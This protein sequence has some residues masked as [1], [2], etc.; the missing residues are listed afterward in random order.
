MNAPLF[1]VLTPVYNP[2]TGILQETIRSVLKQSFQDWELI[3]VDDAS[4]SEDIR[5]VLRH[6]ARRDRRIKLIERATNGGI[7]RASNDALAAAHGEFIALLDH[8][9]LLP[10][11]A[12][13]RVAE[14]LSDD[15]DYVYSD[16][17][18]FDE[19]GRFYDTFRKPDWSPERL[20]HHMYTGHL[21]VIR[22]GLVQAVGGFR[23]GFDGSQ[24]YDLVL[25]VSEKAR[26]IVHI[27]EV[28][29]HWR[30]IQGSA[31]LSLEAKTYA[32]PAGLRA[33][34]EHLER[35]GLDYAAAFGPAP[36]YYRILRSLDSN[37]KVSIIIPTRGSKG[38]VWGEPRFYVLEA[39]RTA[40][41]RT[42]H[43]N[44]EII[45]VYDA[46]TPSS[47]LDE[48]LLIDKDRIVLVPYQEEFNFS[49]KCNYGFLHATGDL[50]VFLNDDTEVISDCWLEEL[51]TPLLEPDVG[52]TG[53]YLLFGDSVVQHAGHSYERGDW[54]HSYRGACLRSSLGRFGDL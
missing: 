1:S 24:D 35:R 44:L 16:E 34:Q 6:F 3:L 26:R 11:N 8:D 43:V 47:V 2:P 38:R 41:A 5:K 15:V 50:V 10:S 51:V 53:A 46:D 23:E 39:V 31:A 20:R 9:D 17:D 40:L 21:S 29:Y 12:L 18:K 42:N 36:G 4:P 27:P 49:R 13:E 25:R 32:Y 22:T 14:V 28:L 45:V 52:M 37:L 54:A 30:A 19:T 33:I 48:L 7:V